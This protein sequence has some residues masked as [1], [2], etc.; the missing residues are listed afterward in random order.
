MNVLVTGGSGYLGSHVKKYFNADDFS[1]HSGSDLLSHVD[2]AA[3]RE[4]DVVIHLAAA[5]DK[6]PEAADEVF[7]VN[8]EGTVN[9]LRSV[10]AGAAFIFASTKDV[11]GRFADNYAEVPEDCPILYSGQS[12]L[13]WSKFIGEQFVNYYGFNRGF[14][15]C[16]FRMS[17]IYAPQTEGT[18]PNFVTH[19]A[20]RINYGE[21]VRFPGGGKPVRDILH[22]E[23]FCKACEAF[24]DSVIRQGTYNIGG[25]GENAFSLRELFEKMQEVSGYQGVVDEENPLPDPIPYNYVTDIGLARR[26]LDWEPSLSAEEGLRTLFG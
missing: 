19:Y 1:R 11:Y 16:V 10:K 2:T 14:R 7:L 22:V 13:E 3:V 21:A 25:G 9:L 5:L 20:N 24:I 4:Y 26:E 15:S 17:T 6:S 18:A 23:D 8:V 12:P